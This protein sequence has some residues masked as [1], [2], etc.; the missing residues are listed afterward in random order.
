M[1]TILDPGMLTLVEDRGRVGH[2]A[3]GVG[4][5]G[6]Y[7]RLSAARANHAVGNRPDAAVLEVL[8]GG[9]H[10]RTDSSAVIALTGATAAVTVIHPDGQQTAAA[11]GDVLTLPAGAEVHLGQATRGMRCYLAVRG[12]IALDPILGSRSADLL[13]GIGPAA[14]A[15]GDELAVGEDYA[16]AD[17][18][19]LLTHLPSMWDYPDIIDLTFIPGPRAEWFDPQTIRALGQHIFTVTDRSNRIGVRV[20]GD[21][22]ARART[23]ELPSEGMVRGSIQVPPDGLPVIFGPDHPVTGGYPVIG[24]LDSRSNDRCGQLRPGDRVRLTL[25]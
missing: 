18:V 2:R 15:D 3:S 25:R 6:A 8:F 14:V 13:S 1:L 10:L 19:P 7:D 20:D 24:V 4:A 11:T 23:A 5:A 16:A 17:W 21:P 12:G 22:I 9:L